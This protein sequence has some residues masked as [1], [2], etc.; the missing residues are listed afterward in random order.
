MSARDGEGRGDALLEQF[1]LAD[2]ATPPVAALSGG[3]AQRLMVARA[4]MHRPV[5]PLPRRA[6][7]RARPAEPHRAVGDPRRA[8]R[9]GPD[10][11]P[12]HALHGGGR[13]A[14]RPARDHRPRPPARA[15]HARGAEARRSA[16]TPSSPCRPTATSTRSPTCSGRGAGRQHGDRA[17]TA[18]RAAQV[19]GADGVLPAVFAAAERDGFAVTDLSV[20]EPTLETV[21]INLTGK[22]LRE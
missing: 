16:P 6:D 4:I 22:D 11:P 20:A 13:P 1:R 21:F 3:M 12:H 15:R 10:D 7:R 19:R 9:R 5:D 2:R 18:S 8:A 14:L 17:S